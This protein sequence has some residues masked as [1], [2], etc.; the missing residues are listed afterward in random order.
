MEGT[1]TASSVSQ[2]LAGFWSKGLWNNMFKARLEV[3]CRFK[4]TNLQIGLA[5]WL[6]W[7]CHCQEVWTILIHHT[8]Q[9]GR[10]LSIHNFLFWSMTSKLKHT[11]QTKHNYIIQNLDLC[12]TKPFDYLKRRWQTR[13]PSLLWRWSKFSRTIGESY[14]KKFKKLHASVPNIV[15]V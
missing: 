11:A 9:S 12:I 14:Q 13:W 3:V 1:R 10:L 5:I 7:H 8:I 2:Q 6:R 4:A 15:H